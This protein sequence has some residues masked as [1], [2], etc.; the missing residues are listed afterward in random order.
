MQNC[1]QIISEGT[2]K[3]I[4]VNQHVIKANAKSGEANPCLTV[5]CGNGDNH[6]GNNVKVDGVVE[7]IYKPNDPL[8]CGA[9]IW[10]ETRGAVTIT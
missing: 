6:Y 9:K 8:S 3:R 2:I 4:H 10:A 1:N 5:K 7:F